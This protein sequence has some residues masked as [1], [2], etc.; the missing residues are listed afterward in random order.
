[1]EAELGVVGDEE[2]R[3]LGDGGGRGFPVGVESGDAEVGG[4]AGGFG[5]PDCLTD[6]VRVATDQS[7][8]P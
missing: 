2:L 1:M 5:E 7:R 3:G 4:E 6:I 8:T